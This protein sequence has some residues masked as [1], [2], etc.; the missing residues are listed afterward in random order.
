MIC[1]AGSFTPTGDGINDQYGPMGYNY[2]KNYQFTVYDRNSVVI[3]YSTYIGRNWN[4]SVNHGKD[5][6]PIGKYNYAVSFTDPSG[7]DR[8][9]YGEFLMFK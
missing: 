3:F 9:Y 8:S 7:K 1:F 6:G 5:T 4:G 2:S